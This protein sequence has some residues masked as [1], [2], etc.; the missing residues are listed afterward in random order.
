M[1]RRPIQASIRATGEPDDEPSRVRQEL[2]E[3][4]A[5]WPAAV[6]IVAVQDGDELET[7][8][9]SAFSTV[10]LDPPLVLVCLWNHAG[11]LPMLREVGRFSVNLLA[12]KDRRAAA[13]AASRL[14]ADPARFPGDDGAMADALVSLS[15]RLWEE[16]PGG[17]HAIVVGEVTE[18]RVGPDAPPLLYADREYRGLRDE[19]LR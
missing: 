5:L 4:L 7:L 8:T 11:I 14:P 9:V 6:T 15:C 1:S 18:V 19:P 13:A 17:D 3:A 2:R 16:Y 10:S 12:E